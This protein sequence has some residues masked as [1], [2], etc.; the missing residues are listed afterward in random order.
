MLGLICFQV[1]V[2]PPAVK[3]THSLPSPPNFMYKPPFISID[4]IDTGQ[5]E[6]KC[7]HPLL[8]TEDKII[9][10]RGR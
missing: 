9:E 4:L 3:I 6:L 5:M 1:T 2:A 7:N 8:L 10:H